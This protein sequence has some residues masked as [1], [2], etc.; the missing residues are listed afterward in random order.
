MRH[1]SSGTCESTT[2]NNQTNV[3]QVAEVCA[4][5]QHSEAEEGSSI[6][7]QTVRLY[8]WFLARLVL[9]FV[10][11]IATN[12]NILPVLIEMLICFSVD[13]KKVERVV[14]TLT[15]PNMQLHFFFKPEKPI[16][17]HR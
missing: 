6:V 2:T 7:T 5:Q 1:A 9:D 16:D 10:V 13:F 8:L 11:V 3:S 17:L 12:A 15:F 14:S 4:T